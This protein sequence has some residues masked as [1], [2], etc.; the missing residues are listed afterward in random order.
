MFLTSLW[1][2]ARGKR[3]SVD[4]WYLLISLKATVP[5][6]NLIFLACLIPPSAGAVFLLV[7]VIAALEGILA[8]LSTDLIPLLFDEI[9]FGSIFE[10]AFFCFGIC[11]RNLSLD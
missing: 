2:G 11:K 3:R 8:L 9:F 6:L 5:G 10:A 4:F 7:L 1:N